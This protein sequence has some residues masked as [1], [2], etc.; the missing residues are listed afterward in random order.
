LKVKVVVDDDQ[1][2]VLEL[3]LFDGGNSTKGF[4][5]F[6]QLALTQTKF[7]QQVSFML[8]CKQW[9]I[10]QVVTFSMLD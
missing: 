4:K 7:V 5:S 9:D 3:K 6:K 8:F 2:E 10:S 1:E